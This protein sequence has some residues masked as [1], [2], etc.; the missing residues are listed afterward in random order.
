MKKILMIILSIVLFISCQQKGP[1]RWTNNSPDI[2][3]IKSLVKDYED[4]NWSSWTAHYSSD[5]KVQHNE[6]KLSSNELQEALSQ[7][8]T[9]YSEYGF[10]HNDGEIFYEQI[11]DDKGDKWVYFWGTW[12]AKLKIDDTEY[13]IPVHLACKMVDG[14]IVEE[15][16]YYNRSSIDAKFK[17]MAMVAESAAAAETSEDSS[18]M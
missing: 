5:A 7:D 11:I 18:D 17:E 3:V 14:K 2:D 16:G 4:G 9:N 6:F 10:S 1:E 8:I 13:V 12:K 15:Y